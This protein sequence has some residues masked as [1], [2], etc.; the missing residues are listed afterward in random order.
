MGPLSQVGRCFNRSEDAVGTA[1]VIAIR[2]VEDEWK[3]YGVS[4]AQ[5][6][7]ERS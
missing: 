5:P 2:Y 3:F 1:E 4:G 6:P 7:V